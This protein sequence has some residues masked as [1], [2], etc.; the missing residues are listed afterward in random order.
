MKKSIFI[1]A[2][3]I[4][5]AGACKQNETRNYT[6]LSGKIENPVS[7]Q[8]LISGQD[9]FRDT[10]AVR[11]DGTF[12]D[13]LY[14]SPGSF[15]LSHGKIFWRSYLE[16]GYDL[17]M[18][19]NTS[20]L[21]GT[22]SY[23]GTGSGEN[24]YIFS[25]FKMLRS[26]MDKKQQAFKADESTFK[27][28]TNRQKEALEHHLN[29]FGG[30]SEG[31]KSKETRNIAYGYLA[32]LTRYETMHRRLTDN[33]GFSI[34]A[35]F[36]DELDQVIYNSGIDFLFSGN[37]R[38]LT[39]RHF[40]KTAREIAQNEG[41][42]ED[43]AYL[44]SISGI[45]NDTIRNSLAYE[46]ARFGITYTN[47]LDTYYE[48]FS[49]ISN[50]TEHRKEVNRSYEVLAKVAKGRPSPRFE[51]Y[52]NFDGSNTSLEDLKG[53]YLYIDVWAT[54]C[55]PCRKEIPYLKQLEKKY[56]GRNVKFV[57]ISIDK[58][59]DKDK[60]K[61]MILEKELGGTQLLADKDW[62]SD[63]VKNYM[64]KGIPRFILLD[65]EGN[66]LDPNAPVPSSG[67]LE[68]IFNNLDI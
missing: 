3:V 7:N 8:L 17:A 10:I 52:L 14:L 26:I 38:R 67:K 24:A 18:A 33:E 21:N 50:D 66:I 15:L 44:K 56:H 39:E 12:R 40:E 62:E 47:D 23:T 43:I 16:S 36:L 51:E 58:Q 9:F 28:I 45:E 57:S 31:F 19:F 60:W 59:S 27:T 41:V 4:L 13:T 29:T 53:A 46:H 5:L 68:A 2:A 54:W 6:V 49:T 61:E 22:L 65:P 1:Y 42:E 20:D 48:L 63:F 32:D 34:S 25:K 55:G 35:D 64:I 37:Y 30:I 11:D